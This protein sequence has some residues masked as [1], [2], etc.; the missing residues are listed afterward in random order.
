MPEEFR[1]FLKLLNLNKL[2]IGNAA[3]ADNTA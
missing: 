1:Y 2:A 3:T